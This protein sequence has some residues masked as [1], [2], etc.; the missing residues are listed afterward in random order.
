VTVYLDGSAKPTVSNLNFTPGQ[1]VP[2]TVIVKIGADGEI[3]LA[4]TSAGTLDLV[5][6]VEGYYGSQ[7]TSGYGGLTP[8]RVLDTR[9]NHAPLPANGTVR[10]YFGPP[11][12]YSAV[13]LNVTVADARQNGYIT[14]YPDG[15]ALLKASNVNFTAGKVSQNEAIVEVGADGYV[16]FTDTSGGTAD[17]IV[18]M[19]GVFASGYGHAF[20][21]MLPTRVVD[22]RTSSQGALPAF[23]TRTVPRRDRCA[24][25]IPGHRRDQ[26]DGHA[27]DRSRLRHRLRHRGEPA[28]DLCGELL[29]RPDRAQRVNRGRGHHRQRRLL[30]RLRRNRR[31]DRGHLR[32]LQLVAKRVPRGSTLEPGPGTL[33]NLQ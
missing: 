8:Q 18:D 14:A 10:V 1:T 27:A 11:P 25:G 30:R 31:S 16:D 24:A 23:S 21:L 20:V 17:L 33:A 26:R 4:N 15:S 22:T 12:N 6:D 9:T 2:N 19:S 5:A 29:T 13:M 3:D 32:V 7:A 28:L